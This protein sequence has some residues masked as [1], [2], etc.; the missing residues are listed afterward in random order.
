MVDDNL[1]L[2]S[3]DLFL[4]GEHPF[5]PVSARIGGL[6]ARDTRHLNSIQVRLGGKPLEQ[7]ARTLHHAAAATTTSANLGLML[8]DQTP[9]LP[10]QIAV[11]ERMALDD[12]LHL[13]YE[14]QNYARR[15]FTLVFELQFSADFN[16]IFEVRGF[17]RSSHGS[18]LRPHMHEGSIHL[19][20]RASDDAILGTIISLNK[21]AHVALRKRST[22]ETESLVFLLPGMDEM[23]RE[24]A[25]PDMAGVVC[26]FDVSIEPRE[27][28]ELRVSV[29]PQP[30]AESSHIA[31]PVIQRQAAS[32][33]ALIESDNPF[34]DR[35]IVRSLDDL[36]ALSTVFPD[37]H[38]MAAGIPWYVAPFGRDSL[39]VALQTLHI[40]PRDADGTLR[41]LASLQGK[42][43]DPFT[44]EQPGKILHEMRYGEM[45]R[46]GEI[47]HRP[48][49]GTLDATPLFVLLFAETSAWTADEELYQDLMPSVRAALRWIDEYGDR[50]GD[51]F[52]EYHADQQPSWRL[53]HQV[54][55]DSHDSLHHDDGSEPYGNIAP[56]E[57][58]GYIYTA[59]MRL[60][61]VAAAFGDEPFARGLRE[62]AA[63]LQRRFDAAFWVEED[64]FY[65]QALDDDKRPVGA[66]TSNPGH[67]LFTGLLSPG[68]AERVVHRLQQP[69]MEAGW[70]IRTL[71]SAAPAYNPMSYHNG[72]IWPH[73]NSIIA[74]GFYRVGAI[75]E[76]HAVFSSLYEAG[77]RSANERLNELYCGFARS[78]Q[79]AVQP[80]PYPT[81]CSPQAWAAGCYPHLVRSALRLEPDIDEKVL[82]VTPS[83]PPFLSRI[84]IR[85]MTVMGMTGWLTV[86]RAG[87]TYVVDFEG[88]PIDLAPA[89]G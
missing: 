58:Q 23:H 62:K 8:D 39:I 76:G 15:G 14:L 83:L 24:P 61:E 78:G 10:H 75:D 48:Y 40:A 44:E 50:D 3:N 88:L 16:D 5:D 77:R 25:P 33:R 32:H 52:V 54:W 59:W 80:I 30:A 35:L 53:R 38:L 79:A 71:S 7:L 72:S 89:G 51:G 70:G 65:A 6:Y 73:D 87:S 20:Y 74:D 2:K 42:E 1:V 66:I 45:A 46:A 17:T 67:L 49:Y 28:W 29:L 41:L 34:F 18:L 81:A 85:E 56:V 86:E 4:L 63:A 27:R 43:E 60:A 26:S 9:L 22:D 36:G 31:V 84:A 12:G 37:G 57:V 11:E 82:R 19:R 13:S 64:G 21:P 69:D 68:R 55:K 47:P